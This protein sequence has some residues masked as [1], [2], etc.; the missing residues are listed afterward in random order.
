[1]DTPLFTTGNRLNIFHSNMYLGHIFP[2]ILF[3]SKNSIIGKYSLTDK[4]IDR[5]VSVYHDLDWL[6]ITLTTFKIVFKQN[7]FINQ[8]HFITKFYHEGERTFKNKCVMAKIVKFIK[9][10][11]VFTFIA[12]LTFNLYLR[13]LNPV[14]ELV[15]HLYERILERKKV[16]FTNRLN[17]FQCY[18]VTTNWT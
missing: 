12:T 5:S 16:L 1:M 11:A 10:H 17:Y 9:K 4:F 13:V 15:I 6:R 3:L 2:I 8:F 7:F 14:W 18:L